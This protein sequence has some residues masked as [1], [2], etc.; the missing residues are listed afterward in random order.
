MN[1]AT[2][3]LTN[4]RALGY[5]PC[6]CRVVPDASTGLQAEGA[7]RSSVWSMPDV[8]FRRNICVLP[9]CYMRLVPSSEQ[10]IDVSGWRRL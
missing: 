9:F 5:Q 3:I 6:L 4:L 10:R 2:K 7:L 8:D 1:F